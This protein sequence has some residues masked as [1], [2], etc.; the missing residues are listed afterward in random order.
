MRIESPLLR[1]FAQSLRGGWRLF[2]LRRAHR[3]DFPPSA[4]LFALL[5]IVDIV[6][7]FA[8]AVAAVG[9]EGELNLYEL[10]RALMFVPLALAL[11][12]IAAR[13]DRGLALLRLPI[14]MAAAGLLFTVLTSG[15][16]LLAQHQWLPFVET[17]WTFFDHFTLVWSCAVVIVG[18]LTLTSGKLWPRAVLGLAGIVLLV[19]PSLWIPVGFMWTPRYDDRGAY[20][21]GSF[22]ALAAESSFYAQQGALERELSALETER[23]GVADIYFLGAG[24]YAGEDVFMK[25]VRMI[26]ALFRERFDGEGRTV[27]LINNPKTLSEHP[28][29]SLTSI[30]DALAHLGSIMNTAEDVLVL[31][32]SSHGSENHELAVDFRPLRFSPI[33]PKAL[34]SA[35]DD[36]G[37][38]WKVVVVSAC[39]SGG[40][41]D[42]LKD[43]QTMVVT[44]AAADRQS[45][46]CGATSEATYL[47]QAL[48][49][50]ALR[51]T[52]SFEEA[53]KAAGSRIEQWER[54]KG[55]TSSQPQVHVGAQVR[56]KLAEIE[57]RLS[58]Q[59]AAAR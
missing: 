40:F 30:R 13:V 6:L 3:A 18:A 46:G 14:A 15:M 1:A 44:A 16:Y 33:T 56:A 43:G 20:A 19:L 27:T 25:E 24:L 57:A 42:A 52:Y 35:L 2:T 4:E 11:G 38:R 47:A 17:Y 49:G 32:V 7:L 58:T 39:Y 51:K 21:T 31:Y 37:I 5:V 29:A 8:F 34:K 28:V 53:V 26:A 36:S 10:P 50:E 41:V 59:P 48:F 23:P 45:F 22:H 54:E 12:M 55:F 9:F